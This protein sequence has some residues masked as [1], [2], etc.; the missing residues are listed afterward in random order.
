MA[1]PSTSDSKTKKTSEDFDSEAR[2]KI[3]SEEKKGGSSLSKAVQ[4]HEEAK[5]QNRIKAGSLIDLIYSE[6]TP[7]N[8]LEGFSK[9]IKSPTG[10]K[11]KIEDDPTIIAGVGILKK[12]GKKVAIIA[13][14][15]P[16][17][18][19]E[20]TTMNYGMVKADGYAISINMME[21]AE[22]NGII[23]NTF[24]DTVGGDPYEY[25]AEKLQSWL[26]SEC[27]AKM[28]SLATRSIS[29][30]I[31]LGGSGGAIALQLAHCR[32]MLSRA[33]FSVITPEGCSA[34][35]FRSSDKVA[36]ALEVLQPT[37]NHML[38]YKIIDDIIKEPKVGGKNYTDEVVKNIENRLAK[39]IKNM[40]KKD[41]EELKNNLRDSI[42]MC[43]R[44]EKKSGFYNVITRKIKSLLP[45][46][47]SSP[48]TPEVSAIQLAIYGAEPFF[49]NDEKD[50]E[51]NIVRAGCHNR[52]AREE[53]EEN[54]FSCPYCNKPES[55]GSDDYIKF[56]FDEETF[57]E[58]S[59]DLTIEDISHDFKI[60][61]YSK[62]RKKMAEKTNSKDSLIVGFG[63][64]FG[65]PV[66]VAICD[67]RFMGG[68]MSAVF[69]EKMRVIV[70][71]CI[72]NNLDLV[73]ITTSGGARMQ[74][75]TVA[76]YQMAKTI[77]AILKLKES[78][79]SYISVLAHPTTGGALASYAVQ[80]DFIIAEQKSII[81]FAGDRVVKLTSGGRG[82]NP[83]TMTPDFY[84]KNGG[85]HASVQRSQ[86]KPLLAGTLSLRNK[87]GYPAIE[88]LPLPAESS[89]ER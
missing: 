57:R 71:Y 30:I 87:T 53:V 63:A 16:S 62:T 18:E 36:E 85:I 86:L 81:A 67:F 2:L 5:S 39:A 75:G 74:E 69:G 32:L 80:G 54:L 25:S 44:M 45:S 10:K 88:D 49:C 79:L 55:L 35:L 58:I 82:V 28:L 70:D 9:Y 23:L 51:G 89:A 41:V 50:A 13:Q 73:S 12:N 43:G 31:G 78:G 83:E 8:E 65:R 77:S 33:E 7:W 72:Q 19:E 40:E 38:K 76:L 59:P 26:I 34:I 3:V 1:N 24:I 17:N 84:L 66:G 27:Q 68:S 20:R 21:Y 42:N 22:K 56:L 48:K 46:R 61:D 29:T 37:A 15:T 4:A 6:F 11:M 64:I 60:A 14:Q 52:Y 47:L